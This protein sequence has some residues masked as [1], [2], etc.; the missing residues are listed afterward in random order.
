MP[1]GNRMSGWRGLPPSSAAVASVCLE[2]LHVPRPEAFAQLRAA[3][4]SC[5]ASV[6]LLGRMTMSVPSRSVMMIAL[7]LVVLV[8]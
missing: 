6:G 3:S 8:S 7:T 4:A 2:V 1:N 5:S